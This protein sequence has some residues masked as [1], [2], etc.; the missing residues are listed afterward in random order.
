MPVKQIFLANQEWTATT[1]YV[2]GQQ[3]ISTAESTI[4]QVTTAGTSGVTLPVFSTTPGQTTVDG[5]VIWTCQGP[6]T[7]P[8]WTVP[9]DFVSTNTIECIGGGGTG[10]NG[11]VGVATGG[12][13]G[14]YAKISNLTLAPGAQI[15]YQLGATATG[16]VG[17]DTWFNGASLA[18]SSVGAKGGS[19]GNAVTGANS[20]SVLPGGLGGQA[21]ASV[22]TTKYS[23]GS[24]GTAQTSIITGGGRPTG[25]GGGGA[26][27][28][29]GPGGDGGSDFASGIGTG[30]SGGGG[31]S[32]GFDGAAA[33]DFLSN[34]GN[35]AANTGGGGAPAGD[36]SNGG[37]G[38]GG[39]IGTFTGCTGGNGTDWNASFGSGGAGG[40]SVDGA[41]AGG[42]YGGGS[43]GAGGGSGGTPQPGGQGLIVITYGGSV[44]G[45]T[46]GCGMPPE[47]LVGDPYS[48]TF[49]FSGGTAPLTFAVITGSLPPGLS[50]N[51]STG[52][53][54]G[55]PTTPGNMFSY[56]IQATDALSNTG[57]TNTC[58]IQIT[59]GSAIVI[60]KC[61][62]LDMP[63]TYGTS[64]SVADIV[65]VDC[66]STPAVMDFS[67]VD[68]PAYPHFT[69]FNRPKHDQDARHLWKVLK[70]A[71]DAA[72][73][74]VTTD[75]TDLSDL[76][77]DGDDSP[78]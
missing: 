67:Y 56:V 40:G 20:P 46:I 55:I 57:T 50:L 77:H 3:I 5:T 18:T 38:A 47:G 59:P 9:T 8:V 32:G 10:G 60:S 22:G 76:R 42:L 65:Y 29:G 31:N 45:P 52:T 24:G 41:G 37:G 69:A 66:Y 36:G 43:G 63:V 44:S 78:V 48:Y 73:S 33:S 53:V 14:A 54:S 30:S 26:A 4:Q 21:S 15:S 68:N 2:T 7:V 75:N 16:P 1:N 27:G 58:S 6:V 25:S 28:P 62:P 49:P 12:G 11:L 39:G 51:M 23:G 72:R 13:G 34:G 17:T 35:N 74:T 71:W 64:P 70:R 19:D 61:P